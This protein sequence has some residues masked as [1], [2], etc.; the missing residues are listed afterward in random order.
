MQ[1]WN[2]QMFT[3]HFKIRCK[4][5][6]IGDNIAILY[7]GNFQ[8]IKINGAVKEEL[9]T[10]KGSYCIYE[11]DEVDYFNAHKVEVLVLEEYSDSPYSIYI[12]ETGEIDTYEYDEI[13][14]IEIGCDIIFKVAN[15][16]I[17]S[18]EIKRRK[19]G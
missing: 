17:H 7:E 13:H 4:E 14:T 9:K 6:D 5:I 1:K 11:M 3:S 8:P 16:K 18:Y 12:Y 2:L 19:I 10:F 15:K